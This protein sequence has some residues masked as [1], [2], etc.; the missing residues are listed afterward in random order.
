MSY[1]TTSHALALMVHAGESQCV[2]V[3]NVPQVLC[4][5]APLTVF[6]LGFTEVLV[7]LNSIMSVCSCLVS[8]LYQEDRLYFLYKISVMAFQGGE[9]VALKLSESWEHVGLLTR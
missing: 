5:S 8:I 3:Y 6:Y 2:S 7:G 4:S 1:V 9:F